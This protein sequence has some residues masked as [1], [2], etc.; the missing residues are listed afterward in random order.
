MSESCKHNDSC[1]PS[2]PGGTDV[3][4]GPGTTTLRV[5]GMDCAD[6]VAAIER[7]LKPVPGVKSVRVNLMGGT[8]AIGHE[9]SVTTAIMIDAIGKAGLR[10]SALESGKDESG[11]IRNR[12]LVSVA[13]SGVLTGIGL[14]FQWAASPAYIQIAVF[15]SAVVAGGWFIFPKAISALRHLDRKSVV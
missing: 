11:S 3:V 13:I 8:V 7:A 10:A 5:A 4:T 15:A 2:D 1:K 9:E 12:R 6:E 14:A